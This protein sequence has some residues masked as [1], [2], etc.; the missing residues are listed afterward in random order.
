MSIPAIPPIGSAGAAGAGSIAEQP[1]SGF[2]SLL[3][4]GLANVSG[5]ERSADAAATGFAVGDGTKV[6]E[7]MIAGSK[8][9]IAVE[10]LTQ[11]RNR[12][13]DAYTE[14]MRLQV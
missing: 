5:L 10:L 3:G 14:I 6:H 2:G 9:Q 1:A 13:V 7:V 11:L 4:Q 8:S 12:A